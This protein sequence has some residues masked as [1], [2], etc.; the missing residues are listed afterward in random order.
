MHPDVDLPT[1][2][3]VID[4]AP[5]AAAAAA[6]ID[7]SSL[8]ANKGSQTFQVINNYGTMLAPPP[9]AAA[10][11]A[12]AAAAHA[13]PSEDSSD[14]EP[15][16]P[17]L[18]R[19]AHR[20]GA[21]SRKS[22]RVNDPPA[23]GSEADDAFL[24]CRPMVHGVQRALNAWLTAPAS[25][26]AAAA[27]VLVHTGVAGIALAASGASGYSP[28]FAQ[29]VN[30]YTEGALSALAHLTQPLSNAK[31][32]D[33][34]NAARAFACAV[35]ASAPLTDALLQGAAAGVAAEFNRFFDEQLAASRHVNQEA[36][37]DRLN[38]CIADLHRNINRGN[39]SLLAEH[40]RR[41]V[42]EHIPAA[43]A[44]ASAAW[45][46]ALA[47]DSVLAGPGPDM[48][49]AAVV[50][51]AAGSSDSSSA[52]MAVPAGDA[53][54]AAAPGLALP[55][56]V[57][58]G[59]AGAAPAGA[60]PA[61]DAP[62]EAAPVRAVQAPPVPVVAALPSRFRNRA[63]VAAPFPM[64]PP[65][66]SQYFLCTVASSHQVDGSVTVTLRDA[67]MP[68]AQADFASATNAASTTWSCK[69]SD[70][71]LWDSAATL[72]VGTWVL[73]Q[74][75][76]GR[77]GSKDDAYL[78]RLHLCEITAVVARANAHWTAVDLVDGQRTATTRRF[79]KSRCCL[80][81]PSIPEPALS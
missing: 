42:D 35:A 71:R 2:L 31:R 5:A 14:D 77:K 66:A 72:T 3:A 44:A 74:A 64:A 33:L 43:L 7:Q 75:D 9:V 26:G 17:G 13:P 59:G 50:D 10:S 4:A 78:P 53:M 79:F 68:S 8:V 67:G 36:F 16:R 57:P 47:A 32:S 6:A 46:S 19:P 73:V 24:A 61:A 63:V 65:S 21:A 15:A 38:K 12:S 41:L 49:V 51:L 34:A 29:I 52:S 1:V 48:V 37:R 76:S 56:G 18:A 70:L 27:P 81:R 58:G 11:G 22:Q 25:G 69:T 23:P 60:A 55:A 39:S 20:Q 40:A 28:M 45:A 30:G 54:A 62:A 80:F